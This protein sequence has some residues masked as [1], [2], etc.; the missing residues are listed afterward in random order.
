MNMRSS[1]AYASNGIKNELITINSFQIPDLKNSR[2][3]AIAFCSHISR[4]MQIVQSLYAIGHEIE[5]LHKLNE[6]NNDSAN[7]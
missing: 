2:D 1:I 6:V 7:Y 4:L 5:Q 3:C